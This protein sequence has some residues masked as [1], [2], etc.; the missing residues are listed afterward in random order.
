LSSSQRRNLASVRIDITGIEEFWVCQS[1]DSAS[2]LVWTDIIELPKVSRKFD[3][4]L[5][6]QTSVAE[7]YQA[8][9]VKSVTDLVQMRKDY[10]VCDFSDLLI[11]LWRDCLAEVYP[12]QLARESRMQRYNLEAEV[13]CRVWLWDKS[14]DC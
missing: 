12:L 8:I 10:L 9:L 3:V 5:V 1:M 7:Y 14:F 13:W 4:S 2:L 11:L 6:T